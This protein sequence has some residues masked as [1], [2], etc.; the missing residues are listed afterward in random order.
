VSK[1]PL[2]FRVYPERK[3]LYVVVNVWPTKKAMYAHRPLNRNHEASCTGTT[4]IVVPPRGSTSRTW[5][6][7]EFAEVN[8]YRGAL[9]VGVVS[10]EFTHA[11]FCWAERRKLKRIAEEEE[12]GMTV[13]GDVSILPVDGVEERFCYALGEMVRQFTQKLYDLGLYG[14]IVRGG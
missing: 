1:S 5:K 9:G 11:A 14:D 8:F 6:R 10:H 4:R 3:S 7:G 2:T 13:R 12:R